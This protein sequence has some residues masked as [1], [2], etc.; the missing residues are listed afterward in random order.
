MVTFAYEARGRFLSS[1][2]SSVVRE[3]DREVATVSLEAGGLFDGP[4]WTW[5]GAFGPEWL[6][7]ARRGD[8]NY[9]VVR[10][11]DAVLGTI[12]RRTFS[13][14]MV[15]APAGRDAIVV[16]ARGWF[17][18]DRTFAVPTGGVTVTRETAPLTF[19]S[20]EHWRLQ[21]PDDVD[22]PLRTLLLALPICLDHRRRRQERSSSH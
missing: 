2:G 22:E 5:Q 15:L 20:T 18:R 1:G 6:L 17:A 13:S 11:D 16:P 19:S 9:E 4:T 14:A 7:H 12:Q 10:A 3:G 8:S 21:L